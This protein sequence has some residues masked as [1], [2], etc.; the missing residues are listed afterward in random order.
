MGEQQLVELG[1]V[2]FRDPVRR[3]FEDLELVRTG[4]VVGC[5]LVVFVSVGRILG[6]PHDERW[7]VDVAGTAFVEGE[8]AV[9]V[10]R[11]FGR[12]GVGDHPHVLLDVVAGETTC[13]EGTS[14]AGAFVVR[15]HRP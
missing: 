9:P 3:A 8:G 2:G 1:G 12:A 5:L 11:R 4:D 7:W 10:E 6:S 14:L 15:E 13:F